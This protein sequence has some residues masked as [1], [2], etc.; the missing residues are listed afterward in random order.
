MEHDVRCLTICLRE[1][2]LRRNFEK[3]CRLKCHRSVSLPGT[4]KHNNDYGRV[5]TMLSLAF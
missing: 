1:P 2:T 5:H 3:L 4:S